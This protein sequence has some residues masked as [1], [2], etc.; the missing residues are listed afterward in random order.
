MKVLYAYSNL[1]PEKHVENTLEAIKG[2]EAAHK[3]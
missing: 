2:W 1:S 3:S